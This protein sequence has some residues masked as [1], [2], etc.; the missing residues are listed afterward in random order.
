MEVF[1]G[2]QTL[3]RSLARPVV[4]TIG[5]FDGVHLGHKKIIELAVEKAH[6]RGGTAVAY[7]FRPHPQIAL[8]PESSVPLLT[9]YDEKLELMAELGLDAIVEEPFSREFSTTQPEQFFNDILLRR[10]NAAE[11]VVGYDFA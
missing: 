5:N 8:R 3:S 9:T 1:R 11:I 4:V 6:S 7:T 2:I 10:L